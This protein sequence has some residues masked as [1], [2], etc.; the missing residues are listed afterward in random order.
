MVSQGSAIRDMGLES[1]AAAVRQSPA[2]SM[3]A[4]LFAAMVVTSVLALSTSA[5]AAT[6][7]VDSLADTG[8][9]GICVLRDAITAA[10]ILMTTNGCTAGTGNDT[11]QFSVTGKIP[12]ASTLPQ[13]MN[14]AG[15]LTINGPASSGITID[16]GAPS[17]LAVE[18]GVRVLQIASGATLNLKD[19]T[20]AHGN[21]FGGSGGAIDNKG[22]LTITNTTFIC[23]AVSDSGGA[24]ENENSGTLTVTDSTFSNN[25]GSN[26]GG[27]GGIANEGTL[28]VTNSTF[29]GNGDVSSGGGIANGG[30]LTVTN[31]TFSGNQA[32]P[33]AGGIDSEQGRSE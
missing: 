15:S 29:S 20:I 3:R 7:T 9:P 26:G 31:S 12:L 22:R 33:G 13:V 19:L 28:T 10:N 11:I 16:G 27:G 17:C 24:I 25:H 30:T 5:R 21:G 18:G 8:G 1:A 14:T 32:L 4:A 2:M 6:I 23:N